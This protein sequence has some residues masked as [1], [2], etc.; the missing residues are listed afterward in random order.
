MEGI[1]ELIGFRTN[2][3]WRYGVDGLIEFLLGNALHHLWHA[4]CHHVVYHIAEC[5]AAANHILIESGYTLV[6]A[7]GLI[8]QMMLP[9]L[10]WCVQLKEAVSA[11]VND[12]VQAGCK[13]IIVVMCGNSHIVHCHLGSKR[14]LAGGHSATVQVI[15][16]IVKDLVCQLLLLCLGD[17]TA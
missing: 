8:G 13:R 6:L 9:V 17:L 12:G 14:M 7:H 16:H 5:F 1:G 3:A 11:F 4:L 2:Q 10:T 15:I